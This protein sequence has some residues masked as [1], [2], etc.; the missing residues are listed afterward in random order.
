MCKCNTVRRAFRNAP[1]WL[2]LAFVAMVLAPVFVAAGAEGAAVDEN[3][4][5]ELARAAGDRFANAIHHAD[6]AAAT[7]ECSLPYLN[8]F[9]D[10]AS[11]A[12]ALKQSQEWFTEFPRR[13]P[14]AGVSYR[15]VTGCVPFDD[16][17]RRLDTAAKDPK[18]GLKPLANLDTLGLGASDRVVLAHWMWGYTILVRV[19]DGK[20]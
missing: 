15:G 13:N 6:A 11:D 9:N 19:R 17:R 1:L 7:A 14:Q 8:Q 4:A 18:S 3:K 12:A 2:A 16:Y 5:D 20:A 10:V